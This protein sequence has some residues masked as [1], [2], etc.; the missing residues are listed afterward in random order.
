MF[1]GLYNLGNTYVTKMCLELTILA[2]VSSHYTSFNKNIGNGLLGNTA[3][4][5]NQVNV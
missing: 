1:T 4:R 5:Q 2:S 3:P